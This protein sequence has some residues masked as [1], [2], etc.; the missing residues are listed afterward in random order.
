MSRV[1]FRKGQQRKFIKKVIVNINSPTLRELAERMQIS[2][3]TLKNYYNESRNLPF[4]LFRDLC[5]IGKVS[6]SKIG[7]KILNDNWG[8]VIGGEKSKRK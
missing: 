4:D 2:Y 7:V 8:Q 1:K 3:S 5:F 6:P